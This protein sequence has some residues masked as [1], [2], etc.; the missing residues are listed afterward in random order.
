MVD[1]Q[2]AIKSCV[3]RSLGRCSE[4]VQKEGRR[5]VANKIRTNTIYAVP[6]GVK[7]GRRKQLREFKRKEGGGRGRDKS[8]TCSD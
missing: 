7:V 3:G 4:K 1:Y 6:R 2:K 5:K 8:G